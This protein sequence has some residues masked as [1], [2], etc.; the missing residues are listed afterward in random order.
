MQAE[1]AVEALAQF[2]PA[3]AKIVRDG[4]HQVIETHE[5]VPGDVLMIEEGDRVSADAR[6]LSGGIEVDSSTLPGESM[7]VFRAAD[8]LDYGIPLLRAARHRLQRHDVHRGRG[9]RAGVRDR[10]GLRARPDRRAI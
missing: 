10:H 1:R 5:L 6:P 9:A 8:L 3:L 2:I 7:L 4:K